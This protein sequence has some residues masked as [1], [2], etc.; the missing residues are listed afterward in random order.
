MKNKQ[1]TS[2][3][4]VWQ[5][6]VAFWYRAVAFFWRCC[7]LYEPI[8]CLNFYGQKALSYLSNYFCLFNFDNSTRQHWQ[9]CV[10]RSGHFHKDASS[11]KI[12]HLHEFVLARWICPMRVCFCF[13]PSLSYFLLNLIKSLSST[14]PFDHSTIKDTLRTVAARWK[15]NTWFY[16]SIRDFFQLSLPEFQVFKPYSCHYEDVW[17]S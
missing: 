2:Y 6:V 7:C 4:Y 3:H 5:R 1:T 12:L 15:K 17:F 13:H 9:K 11:I 16:W 8:D 10:C 14:L